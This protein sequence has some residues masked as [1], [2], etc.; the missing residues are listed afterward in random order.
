MKTTIKLTKPMQMFESVTVKPVGN[1]VVIEAGPAPTKSGTVAFLLT[2][3]QAGALIFGM[4]QA[5]EALE[6]AELRG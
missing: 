6:V 5:A 1:M 4:E 3:D 2:L